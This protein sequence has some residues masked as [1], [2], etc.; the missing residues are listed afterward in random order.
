[1]DALAGSPRSVGPM[2]D[3]SAILE[4][5]TPNEELDRRIY[6]MIGLDRELDF[7]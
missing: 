2:V 3:G 7:A 6:P 1:M 5:M 4:N